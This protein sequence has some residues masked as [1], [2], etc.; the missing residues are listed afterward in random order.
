MTN[1]TPK[2]RVAAKAI[3]ENLQREAPLPVGE[4]L[5][6]SGY[7]EKTALTPKTVTDTIGFKQALRDLG[8]TEELI[9]TAL[10]EDIQAKPANRIQEL[11]LGAEVLGMTKRDEEPQK[12][13]GNTYNFIFSESVQQEVKAMEDRIKA[14]LLKPHVQENPEH[15]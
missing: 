13:Q 2:Q 6:K 4:I 9:T 7:S 1:P 14:Q 8:L 12:Q 15:S 3:V 11:K 10:V 5:E